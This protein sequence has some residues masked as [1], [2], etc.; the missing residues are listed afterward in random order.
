[1]RPALSR[2]VEEIDESCHTTRLRRL[3]VKDVDPSMMFAFL[4]RDEK[5]WEQWKAAVGRGRGAVITVAEREPNLATTE[6]VEA[7]DEVIS[8][9]ENE[10][11]GDGE[12]V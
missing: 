4:I 7:V 12:R 6:R 3:H 1:V 2:N 11:E 8:E 9:S 5:D 10:D